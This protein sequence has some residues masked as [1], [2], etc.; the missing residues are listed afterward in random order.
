[1]SPAIREVAGQR[2]CFY[3]GVV[4]LVSF[5]S[6][7]REVSLGESR[8]SNDWCVAVVG[9]TSSPVA[10]G[11]EYSVEFRLSSR[12]RGVPQRENGVIV[13]LVGDTGR[14]YLAQ[15]DPEAVPFNVMLQPGQ[16]ITARR[17]FRVVGEKGALGVVI[18]REGSNAIPG[19]FIIGD[20]GSLFHRRAIVR[21][22]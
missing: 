19:R 10:G 18:D 4:S 16:A 9:V 3:T 8:C 7:Q 1:V 21:I 13:Y 20:D 11:K 14:R 5:L 22:P 2:Q 17:R 12:A 15:P 6:P